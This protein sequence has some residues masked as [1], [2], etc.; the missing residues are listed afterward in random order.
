VRFARIFEQQTYSMLRADV[1][2]RCG[3]EEEKLAE[4]DKQSEKSKRQKEDW[5]DSNTDAHANVYFSR[6]DE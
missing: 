3:G 6:P 5:E 2:K 4:E 1:V